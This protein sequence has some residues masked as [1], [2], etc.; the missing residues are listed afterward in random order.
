MYNNKKQTIKIVNKNL[1]VLEVFIIKKKIIKIDISEITPLL[2]K[3][4]DSVIKNDFSLLIHYN[5]YKVTY[6]TYVIKGYRC[7]ICSD[8]FYTKKELLNILN[9]YNIIKIEFKRNIDTLIYE[10]N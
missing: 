3:C 1:E 6:I 9:K 5:N 8:G 10:I 7:L 2:K 4:I